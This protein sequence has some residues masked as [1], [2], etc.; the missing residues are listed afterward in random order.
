MTNL[1]QFAKD[2]GTRAVGVVDGEE[3]HVVKGARSV[4][5]LA[6]EAIK[7]KAKLKSVI[8][9][10]GLGKSIDAKAILN[11]GRM[12]APIDHPDPAHLY[13][14]GTGLTHLGSASARDAM[15]K[16]DQQAVEA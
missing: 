7:R 1:I 10:H 9:E 15:H 12:L 8:K 3:A 13:V 5:A 14:T 2:N 11:E 16:S 6:L 4:Y